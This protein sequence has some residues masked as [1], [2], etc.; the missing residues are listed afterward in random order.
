MKALTVLAN[1]AGVRDVDAFIIR[2]Q[3]S[4][5]CPIKPN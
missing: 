1:D 5:T 2:K 3:E 4:I